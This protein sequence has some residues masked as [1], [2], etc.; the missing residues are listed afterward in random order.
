M[1]ESVD[2]SKRRRSRAAVVLLAF[3]VSAGLA[4][5]AAGAVAPGVAGLAHTDLVTVRA[6]S[7]A[8]TC[9]TSALC[10]S[11]V[12]QAYGVS[13]LMSNATTNGT[14]QT[15][16]L[17]DACGDSGIVSDLK[18][19]D[20]TFGLP[21]AKITVY[22]PQGKPCSDPFGWGIETALDVE[23][24]H[25]LAPGASIALVEARTA[26]TTDLYGAWN[27][28]LAHHLGNQ[29]SNSW[30]GSG[31][32]PSTARHLLSNATSQHVTVLA[33][34]GDSGAWGSGQTLAAQQ[35]ADCAPVVTVGGTTLHVSSTGG[36]INETG[37]SGSGGG[38][39]PKTKEPKYESTAKISDSYAELAKPDVAAVADPNTGVWVYESAGGGWY[40]VG[41][42]SVA[43]PIWAGFFA[44][45][46]DQ[47]AAGSLA[48]L[49]NVDPFLYTTVYGAG[50][51]SAHYAKT[52]ND[53]I[54]GNNGWAAGTGWDP[55]TGL[56]SFQGSALAALLGTSPAA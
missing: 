28:S 4:V 54:Y 11:T 37:W 2:G 24:A 8:V 32:C 29:I 44:D 33:S 43:C 18:T 21:A 56:G 42:T 51:T 53:P 9:S 13:S 19:F 20:S 31:G 26:S 25:V 22:T 36:Y 48:A 55:V 7:L 46:N 41:G 45:V 38:Y 17:I 12:R 16:V 14:G 35:P 23:W 30:G 49:G 39:V 34:A 10:P 52:M 40:I 6:A 27:Y 50:G 3:L 47:R 1:R 5:P 15:V